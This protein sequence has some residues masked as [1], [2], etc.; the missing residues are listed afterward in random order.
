MGFKEGERKEYDQSEW[1]I[2]ETDGDKLY[3]DQF[4]HV[5]E[6][7]PGYVTYED[8]VELYP[9]WELLSEEEKERINKYFY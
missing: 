4:A 3:F 7:T 9:Q 2:E 6:I 8:L 1:Y 5:F